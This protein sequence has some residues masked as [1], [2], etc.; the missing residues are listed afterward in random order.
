MIDPFIDE[1][2]AIGALAGRDYRRAAGSFLAAEREGRARLLRPLRVLSLGLAGQTAEARAAIA[3]VPAMKSADPRAW[4]WLAR[5]F[6][7]ATP[8]FPPGRD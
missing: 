1:L 7:E 6:G 2:L 4:E 8:P 3:E 5:R